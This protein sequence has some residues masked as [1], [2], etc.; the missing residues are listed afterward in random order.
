MI[1]AAHARSALS[2]LMSRFTS[3]H[4]LATQGPWIGGEARCVMHQNLFKLARLML[5][6][7]LGMMLVALIGGCTTRPASTTGDPGAGASTSPTPTPVNGAP[8][9]TPVNGAPTPTPVNGAPTPTPVSTARPTP[10]PLSSPSCGNST[11]SGS[12]F[13]TVTVASPSSN[14]TIIDSPLTN[15][16]PQ[17]ILHVASV[18]HPP[19]VPTVPADG[20][21]N[22]PIGVSYNIDRQ[23]WVIAYVNLGTVML[24]GTWFQVVVMQPSSAACAQTATLDTISGNATR[25]TCLTMP[26]TDTSLLFVTRRLP[27]PGYTFS[28]PVIGVRHSEVVWSVVNQD[29]SAMG[30]GDTFN[31]LSL[32]ATTSPYC[33]SPADSAGLHCSFVHHATSSSISGNCTMFDQAMFTSQ[34]SPTDVRM[35]VTQNVNPGISPDVS[36]NHNLGVKIDDQFRYAVCNR[37][38]APMPVGASFNVTA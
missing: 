23:R 16:S 38:L 21:N 12:F 3:N 25:I 22:Q 8:T 13:Y 6:I 14:A 33:L 1:T 35:I 37:D 17:V 9:P 19:L 28:L 5:G 10:T 11:Q 20:Y 2:A 18:V 31:V 32:P 30:P 15:C 24:P 27:T 29:G 7:M 26:L 34:I 4:C 36:N